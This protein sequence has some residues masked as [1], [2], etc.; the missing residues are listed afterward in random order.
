M[1]R[2]SK[3]SAQTN[4]KQKQDAS[5]G[6]MALKDAPARKNARAQKAASAA[7]AEEPQRQ[8]R[9]FD[10]RTKRDIVGV[11]FA[12][13][14]VALFVCAVMPPSGFV[15]EVLAAGMHLLLGVGAYVVPFVMATVGVCLLVRTEE[16]AS[17]GWRMGVGASMIMLAFMV[18]MSLLV[19]HAADDPNM[20]FAPEML[21]LRGGYVGAGIA[22]VFLKAFGVIIGCVLTAGLAVAGAVIIG[23]SLSG[24]LQR[25]R[26]A[27]SAMRD[28]HERRQ[29]ARE[30]V[31]QAAQAAQATKRVR[32]AS[33]VPNIRAKHL[34][35]WRPSMRSAKAKALLPPWG[36]WP[37][38]RSAFSTNPK[39]NPPVF[40]V[41][42]RFPMC[43]ATFRARAVHRNRSPRRRLT[44]RARKWA[45]RTPNASMPTGLLIMRSMRK[46]PHAWASSPNR[47]AIT[48]NR[49]WL[50]NRP[51]LP[52]PAK[53]APP[54]RLRKR[55]KPPCLHRQG[56]KMGRRVLRHLKRVRQEQARQTRRKRRS[57][58]RSGVISE[59]LAIC[60]S[61]QR[62]C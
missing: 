6:R 53:P 54:Q 45:G 1:A 55:P 23:F 52:L 24:A 59:R 43:R 46:K 22:W 56:A 3:N 47:K 19:P 32:W 34:L 7:H 38:P 5:F 31:R 57:S 50:S 49:A 61:P 15:T 12:V 51:R 29:A 16:N 42:I 37:T 10:D 25:M 26:E 11:V 20:L 58:A 48:L 39:K 40:A 27:G 30:V 13:A 2:G 8:P 35:S 41:Q 36:L 33:L 9:I 28:A 44:N 60:P 4:S 18:M 62:A 21:V 17:L 14:A